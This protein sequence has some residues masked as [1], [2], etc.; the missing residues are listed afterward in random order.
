MA[1]NG[2]ITC[3][4]TPG[5]FAREIRRL[6]LAQEQES[7]SLV[8]HFRQRCE[9]GI[10]APPP[11][12]RGK[13]LCRTVSASQQ[14]NVQQVSPKRCSQMGCPALQ[15]QAASRM[16]QGIAACTCSALCRAD[17]YHSLLDVGSSRLG[18]R[19]CCA[20]ELHSLWNDVRGTLPCSR[21]RHPASSTRRGVTAK[22]AGPNPQADALRQACCAPQALGRLSSTCVGLW[23][24]Q[25]H[26]C[27]WLPATC[28]TP[29]QV[30]RSLGRAPALPTVPGSDR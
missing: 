9:E 30:Q 19:S 25:R 17:L 22:A 7:D 23:L 26:K 4:A 15:L 12:Q 28:R 11:L 5:A 20:I 24:L 18:E 3:Q 10:A 16:S 27:C 8:R 6:T 13:L 29:K 2:G 21:P 14:V 1:A